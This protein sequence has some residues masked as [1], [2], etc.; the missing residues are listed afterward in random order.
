ML[1]GGLGLDHT[2]YR[3]TL[4][5]LAETRQV[6]WPDLRANGRSASGHIPFC[7]EQLAQ[8]VFSLARQLGLDSFN[9]LG[10]SYG[11]F[12]AQEMMFLQSSLQASG[13]QAS[14]LQ[15]S[16]LHKVVLVCTRGGQKGAYEAPFGHLMPNRPQALLDI[17]KTPPATDKECANNWFESAPFFTTAANVDSL[18]HANRHTLCRANA[19]TRSDEIYETWSSFDRLPGVTNATLVL[20][21]ALD[22]ICPPIESYRI[23]SRLPHATHHVFAEGNHYP[24]MECPNEFFRIVEE[25]SV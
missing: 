1:L 22:G 2:L 4:W 18:R 12:V 15:A 17:W 8:D 20:S 16:G 19:H 10:H 7:M 23:G 5:K 13:L 21:S 11:G 9:V 3:E 14:S 25:C 6:I 24:W